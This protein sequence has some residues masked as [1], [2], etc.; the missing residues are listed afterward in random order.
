MST[1]IGLF[2]TLTLFST[3]LALGLSL[4]RE[5]LGSWCQQPALPL[6]VL[7]GSCLLVPLLA[8]LLLQTPWSWQIAQPVRFAIALMALCPSAP[9]ALRKAR[10]GGGDHQLAA[11]IQVGAALAAI[12]SIP[13]L[14][15]AFRQ[16]FAVVGWEVHPLDVALQVG[17]VQ[18]LPLLLGL[19]LRH[20]Q[21]RFADQVE[22]PLERIANLLLL[23]LLL[24]VLLKAGPLLLAF[25]PANL[26]ALA[27]MAL[28]VVA[29][30]LIGRLM[31][32]EQG[33]AHG[34]TTGLVTAMRNPGLA[35]LFASR[36]GQELAGLRL[37]ILAYVLITVLVSSPWLRL[38]RRMVP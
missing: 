33:D 24:L 36:H 35:L 2:I 22:V 27:L 16:T 7:L 23:V 26:P 8:L 6:R 29:S 38:S 1:A 14:G 15:L 20:W 10:K 31:A 21:P 25:V 17:R 9:L 28:L 5:A 30:L 3:M 12:V 18:V 34:T 13:L 37:A 32:A 19:A 4:D 11:L